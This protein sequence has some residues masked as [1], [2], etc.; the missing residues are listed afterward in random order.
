MPSA[1]IWHWESWQLQQH[2]LLFLT[3]EVI[4]SNSKFLKNQTKVACGTKN[5]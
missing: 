4:F 5:T 1:L 3:A 2:E